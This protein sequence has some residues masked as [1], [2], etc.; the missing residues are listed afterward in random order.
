MLSD[1]HVVISTSAVTEPKTKLKIYMT[2]I[3]IVREI[4]I[5][6]NIPLSFIASSLVI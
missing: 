3:I 2:A 4:T 6:K 1:V 5:K